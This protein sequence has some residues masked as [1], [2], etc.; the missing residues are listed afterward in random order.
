[1]HTCMHINFETLQ[2]V[3][4]V[5][6]SAHAVMPRHSCAARIGAYESCISLNLLDTYRRIFCVRVSLLRHNSD[7]NKSKQ[8]TCKYWHTFSHSS[9]DFRPPAHV[10]PTLW[11][12]F[13]IPYAAAWLAKHDAKLWLNAKYTHMAEEKNKINKKRKYTKSSETVFWWVLYFI[14]IGE[15]RNEKKRMYV[16]IY[17]K[18]RLFGLLCCINAKVF[19]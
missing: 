5:L 12:N 10:V 4:S 6:F 19:I 3:I 9:Q 11:V 16:C 8:V 7:N 13:G 14:E 2:Q 15:V 17:L 1:M 18:V